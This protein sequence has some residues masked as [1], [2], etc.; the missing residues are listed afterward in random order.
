MN[1]AQ[2]PRLASWLLRRLA[3]GQKRESL[4]GDLDE[5]FAR[6]RS[7]FWYW[8][9]VLSA[10]LAGIAA[11]LREHPRLAV[12]SVILTWAVVLTWVE[13]TW[14]LYL[15]VSENWVNAWTNG[16]SG[17]L[18]EFWHP[19]GGGLCLIWC[20]G[21][22]LGGRVVGRLSPSH[23]PAMVVASALAQ[24]PLTLWWGLPVWWHL[25]PLGPARFNV[26]IRIWLA[27]VLVGIPTSTLLGGLWGADEVTVQALAR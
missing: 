13:S 4:I 20:V 26:P 15:W 2:R 23:R 3:C 1:T 24:V 5:Q 11:D 18:F 16:G 21:S 7:S 17:V 22:A 9:Q 12:R 25:N 10:I 6:G 8:R 14:Q 19:F 27:V